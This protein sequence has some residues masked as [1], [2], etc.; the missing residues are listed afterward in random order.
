MEPA[1][2]NEQLVMMTRA[3]VAHLAG[4]SDRRLAYW[5]RT[6]V[7]RPT[8]ETGLAGAR[9]PIRLYDYRDV[10]SVM[11]IAALRERV[12][13]QHIRAIVLHLQR[14]DFR[15]TEVKFAIA[16]KHVHFQ[17]PD[18]EWEDVRQA[19][20]IVLH[21]VLELEPLRAQVLSASRRQPET[22]GHI[23]KRR[24]ARGSKPLVAGTRV[25]VSSV[26]AYLES[27]A[28]TE[29]ILSAYPALEPADVDEVR[30]LASA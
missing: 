21:Q 28:T 1:R 12:S 22:L 27:G 16:G 2:V 24:G 17:R 5:E 26:Q 10:M 14:L 29:A 20:Q 11:V 30:R 8:M 15:V 19:G 13:L 23:E 6:E 25:P 18:G 4:M 3:K 9:S 7:L